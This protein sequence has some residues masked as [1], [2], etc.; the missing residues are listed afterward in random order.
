MTRMLTWLRLYTKDHLSLVFQD[1]EEMGWRV[2]GAWA[3]GGWA[4]GSL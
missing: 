2:G 4:G 1:G 3:V